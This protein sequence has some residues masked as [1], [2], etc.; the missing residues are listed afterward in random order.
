VRARLRAFNCARLCDVDGGTLGNPC[1]AGVFQLSHSCRFRISRKERE[2]RGV[3][4]NRK[5]EAEQ[6]NVLP[7]VSLRFGDAM[8][9]VDLAVEGACTDW[10]KPVDRPHHHTCWSVSDLNTD[11]NHASADRSNQAPLQ[12]TP[13][14]SSLQSRPS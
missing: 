14:C 3:R 11:T 4:R 5:R 12:M 7:S 10:A 1:R 9:A 6:R 8:L 2:M 13:A